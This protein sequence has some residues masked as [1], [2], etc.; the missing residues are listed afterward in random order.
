MLLRL[1][2]FRTAV[3]FVPGVTRGLWRGLAAALAGMVGATRASTGQV[4]GPTLPGSR[5]CAECGIRRLGTPQLK[6]LITVATRRC[7]SLWYAYY[8]VFEYVYTV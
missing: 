7:L 1:T 4:V 2:R 3:T 8:Y 5:G 6:G